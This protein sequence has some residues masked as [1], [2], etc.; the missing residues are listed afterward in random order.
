MNSLSTLGLRICIIGNS[1]AGKSTLAQHL[2]KRLHIAVCHLDQIA[3]IPNTNWEPRDRALLRID[4][5]AFLAQHEQWVIE[6]NYSYLMPE[7]FQQA[8][9]IIWLDFSRWGSA[10]RFIKRSLQNNKNRAGNLEGARQQFNF[11]MLKHILFTVPKNKVKYQKLIEQSGVPCIRIRS[12]NA[13]MQYYK[14]WTI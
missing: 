2:G 11:K 9:T 5:Q 8:T 3:H 7:R 1:A 10:Y 6:G 14:T 12:F 4:H 13:L